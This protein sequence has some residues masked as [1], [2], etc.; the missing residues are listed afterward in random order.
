M[1]PDAVDNFFSSMTSRPFLVD[2]FL[3]MAVLTQ[4]ANRYVFCVVHEKKLSITKSHQC[5]FSFEK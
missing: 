2:G 4:A 3:S 5:V 1:S